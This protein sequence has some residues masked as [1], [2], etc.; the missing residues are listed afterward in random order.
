MSGNHHANFLCLDR[1]AR[2]FDTGHRAVFLAN[3]GDFAILD[4]IDAA[5]I[6]ATGKTPGHG[7]VPRHAAARLE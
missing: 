1:A 4:D 3:R 7:I 2:G 6:G 5:H